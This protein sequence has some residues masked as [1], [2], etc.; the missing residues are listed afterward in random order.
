VHTWFVLR[1]CPS[2]KACAARKLTTSA[3]VVSLGFVHVVKANPTPRLC[4]SVTMLQLFMGR[5]HTRC[6]PKNVLLQSPDPA[7]AQG[8]YDVNSTDLLAR[9]PEYGRTYTGANGLICF[10][11]KQWSAQKCPDHMQCADSIDVP[12]PGLGFLSYD[13]F[14]YACI[15]I[16]QVSS[17]TVCCCF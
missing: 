4:P 8:T 16:L 17:Q 13:N 9:H 2:S 3:L 5:L 1:N 7:T 10:F 14:L 6:W 15:S 11:H 12:N